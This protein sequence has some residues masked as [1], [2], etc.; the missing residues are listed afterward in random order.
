MGHVGRL[1][2]YP[3]RAMIG[4]AMLNGVGRFVHPF[5]GI[6][7]SI[8][9]NP[10]SVSVPQKDGFTLL[11][12]T[13]SVVAGGKFDVKQARGEQLPEGWLLN[14]RGESVIDFLLMRNDN[15]TSVPPLGGPQLRISVHGRCYRRW[16]ISCWMQQSST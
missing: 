16:T 9:P 7:R 12:M 6:E 14:S 5:G 8:P 13:T 11:D 3:P 15:T 2:E 1:G 4:I 10:I